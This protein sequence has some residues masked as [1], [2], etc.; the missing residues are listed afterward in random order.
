[1]LKR[2]WY[3]THEEV[4]IP[5]KKKS[6]VD[7]YYTGMSEKNRDKLR[8]RFQT[9]TLENFA[10][11]PVF[12]KIAMMPISNEYLI[13]TMSPIA[14]NAMMTRELTLW[15]DV[16]ALPDEIKTLI[17]S[18]ILVPCPLCGELKNLEYGPQLAIHLVCKKF[19]G[20][21]CK[22]CLSHWNE[23]LFLKFN[24]AFIRTSRYRNTSAKTNYVGN[25]KYKDQLWD[26]TIASDIYFFKYEIMEP[27]VLA[28]CKSV[29]APFKTNGGF[30]VEDGEVKYRWC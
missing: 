14:F 27:E 15:N 19:D 2:L 5:M 10:L 16:H 22:D 21:A 17:C 3:E 23:F 20:L 12:A 7:M 4:F 9:L 1:M 8:R 26:L 13:P 28:I 29:E 25:I 18:F 6:A 30:Y 24:N 11:F